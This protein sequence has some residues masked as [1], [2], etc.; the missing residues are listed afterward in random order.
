MNRGKT[1]SM[2]VQE[3]EMKELVSKIRKKEDETGKRYTISSF[4]REFVLK[5]YLNGSSSPSQEPENPPSQEIES[6]EEKPREKGP[7]DDIQF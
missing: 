1:L 6:N 3:D 5:P 7:W 2:T 4:L